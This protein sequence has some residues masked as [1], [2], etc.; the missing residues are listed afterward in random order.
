MNRLIPTLLVAVSVTPGAA[1]AQSLLSAT[2]VEVLRYDTIPNF[3]SSSGLYCCATHINESGPDADFIHIRATFDV[4]FSDEVDRVSISGRDIGLLLPGAEEPTAAVGRFSYIP[5]FEY[6]QMSLNPRR[7][8]DWPDETEQAFY[9]GVFLVG[10]DIGEAVLTVGEA[11]PDQLQVPVSLAV[12]PTPVIAPARTLGVTVTGVTVET[13]AVIEDSSAR[14]DM[15]GRIT[16]LGGQMLRVDLTL[17]PL[18]TNVTDTQG[19]DGAFFYYSD[20]LALVGPRGTPYPQVGRDTGDSLHNRWSHSM[21][22]EDTPPSTDIS[23]VF[24]GPA[25]PGRYLVFYLSDKV[26]EFMLE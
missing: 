24:L 3:G 6:G 12:A 22:W 21:R 18:M 9:S 11:G 26:A 5:I 13:E 20:Q 17:Q 15:A 23:I 10:N 2:E 14:Q 4:A 19:G 1:L 25:D 16:P 7:P 8:R